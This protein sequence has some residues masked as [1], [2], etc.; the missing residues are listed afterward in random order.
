[1]I[2]SVHRAKNKRRSNS[3]RSVANGSLDQDTRIYNRGEIGNHLFLWR[4]ELVIVAEFFRLARNPG[5]CF[6]SRLFPL[7]LVIEEV[8]Q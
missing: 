6:A 4:D 3:L 7:L 8:F 2:S 1:M 5:N